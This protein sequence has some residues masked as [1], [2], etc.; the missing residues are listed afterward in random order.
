MSLRTPEKIRSLQRKLYVK[1]KREPRVRF[2]ALY[3]KVYRADILAHAY[4]LCRSR[5]GAAGVDGVTFGDIERG[6]REAWLEDLAVEL[7]VGRYRPRAVRRVLIPKSDG[8]ERPLGIPTVRDRVVQTATK[9]VLEPIFEADFEPNAYGYRPKK[10]ALDAVRAVR[11]AIRRGESQVVDADLSSYFDTIPHQPLMKSVARRISDRKVLSLIKTWLKV[12]V[13]STDDEGRTTYTGGKLSNC[14][15]P[16]GGVISPLLA[17]IYIHR[18][19]KAWKMFD[20]EERLG[21]RIINYADDLVIV[22]R[23]RPERA[24]E[25][26]GAI[27]GKLGLSL[28]E[29]K[30]R[31][32]DAQRESF[33]FLGYSF[34]PRIDPWFGQTYVGAAPSKQQI[35]RC[36]QAV[37]T[38]LR[39]WNRAPLS[40]VVASVNRTL[41]G[42][43][44]YFCVD[45]TYAAYRALDHYARFRLRWYLV[46][47]HQ[48]PGRGARRFDHRY[49]YETLGLV[50][51]MK[52]RRVTRSA[53]SS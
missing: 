19:L 1:A 15:T 2:Y 32:C 4:R 13:E 40:E 53:V 46:R 8:G 45:A 3:D 33:D 31:V 49:L 44:N 24:L 47:R 26:L 52:R 7:R 11:A 42:W 39:P 6:G 30:T 38:L 12:P 10:S 22:C 14:G 17:N 16:Q 23:S 18:L 20:L 51:L 9:L 21:A 34:G 48:V 28:N 50:E 43:A 5:G 35:R 29:Q 25:W 37:R 41:E 27:V 36:K